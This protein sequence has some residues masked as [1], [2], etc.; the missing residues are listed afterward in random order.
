MPGQVAQGKPSA[1]CADFTDSLSAVTTICEI[2]GK[3]AYETGSRVS[4]GRTARTT[5]RR[6]LAGKQRLRFSYD[7]AHFTGR[8]VFGES[9]DDRRE[10]QKAESRNLQHTRRGPFGFQ[11]SAFS[12]QLFF[13]IRVHPWLEF[14]NRKSQIVN[15]KFFPPPKV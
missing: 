8:R 3:H 4:R 9:G 12:F 5:K 1:D 13:R 11:L 6:S 10:K 14:V 15:R 7:A 2:C